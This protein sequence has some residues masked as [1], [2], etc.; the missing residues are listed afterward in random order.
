VLSPTTIPLIQQ[1]HVML[2]TWR[3]MPSNTTTQERNSAD[4]LIV[5]V[6]NEGVYAAQQTSQYLSQA[7]GVPAAKPTREQAQN[8]AKFLGVLTNLTNEQPQEASYILEVFGVHG[9][10]KQLRQDP[11]AMRNLPI[12][13]KEILQKYDLGKHANDRQF[14]EQCLATIE[15]KR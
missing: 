11:V 7:T 3:Q 4:M 8:A 9:K 10:Y 14:I 6:I 2:T 15:S 5:S 12:R 13:L 1:N